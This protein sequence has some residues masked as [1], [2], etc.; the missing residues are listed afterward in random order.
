ML[1]YTMG[2]ATPESLKIGNENLD[3]DKFLYF[4]G[5]RAAGG[6]GESIVNNMCGQ[7][8]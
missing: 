1:G 6:A 7:K 4:E 5:T 3:V 2:Q 8:F